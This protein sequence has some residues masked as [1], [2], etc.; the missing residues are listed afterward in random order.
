MG[1]SSA[2]F[3]CVGGRGR[4]G[5]V[6]GV[7]FFVFCGFYVCFFVYYSFEGSVCFFFVGLLGFLLGVLLLPF[8]FWFGES[9]FIC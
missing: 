4:G 7:G 1:L 3:F 6:G 8:V 9:V 2:C 5:S